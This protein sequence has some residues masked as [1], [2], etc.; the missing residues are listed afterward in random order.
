MSIDVVGVDSPEGNGVESIWMRGFSGLNVGD[1][2]GC[3]FLGVARYQGVFC[4]EFVVEC[5]ELVVVCVVVKTRH[6]FFDF[7]LGCC[8]RRQ[9][10]KWLSSKAT[11]K[12]PSYGLKGSSGCG[13][14]NSSGSFTAFRMTARTHCP[15]TARTR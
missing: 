5:G 4:G 15:R 1:G 8:S 3:D 10:L 14:W 2:G 7:F 9:F 13:E 6:G 12:T 11:A